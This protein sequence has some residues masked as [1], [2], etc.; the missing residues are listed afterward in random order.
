MEPKPPS[1]EF[2][3][4]ACHDCQWHQRS[5][6]AFNALIRGGEP[7]TEA[8]IVCEPRNTDHALIHAYANAPSEDPNKQ[9]FFVLTEGAFSCIRRSNDPD[10]VPTYDID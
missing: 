4:P 10:F 8:T 3:H 6:R 1:L 2:Q 9:S 5:Q 7:I